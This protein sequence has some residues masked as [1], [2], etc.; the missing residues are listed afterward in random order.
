MNNSLARLSYKRAFLI[1]SDLV[2]IVL[3][4]YV[5][6]WI[7]YEDKNT[8]FLLSWEFFGFFATVALVLLLFDL[9]K[10]DRSLLALHRYG[11]LFAAISALVPAVSLYLFVF[12]RADI[13]GR[14]IIG[15]FFIGFS[16][17][18][19]SLRFLIHMLL[20]RKTLSSRW[21]VLG[22]CP[23]FLP[24][25][26]E[27]EAEARHYGIHLSHSEDFCEESARRWDGFIIC[28]ESLIPKDIMGAV[29]NRRLV[30]KRV[31]RLGDFYESLWPKVSLHCLEDGWFTFSQGFRLLHDRLALKIKRFI[32][33][34]L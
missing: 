32:D 3:C 7:R 29:M 22:H 21:L 6:R 2:G 27:V 16:L 30:G 34:C 24:A 14:G 11:R 4:L 9:Y 19:F 28:D 1:I 5:A 23:K 18:I 10:R 25:L 17:W 8:T 33:I 20:Q 31:Y 13:F 12:P 26:E 15:L